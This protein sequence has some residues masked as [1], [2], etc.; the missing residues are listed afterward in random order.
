MIIGYLR[1][2]TK[3]QNVAAQ[4]QVI[5]DKYQIER[6]YEDQAASGAVKA[7]NRPEFRKMAEFVRQ[8][9][10]VVVVAIDRLGRNT[11]DVLETVQFLQKKGVAVTSLRE[12]FDLASPLGTAMLAIVSAFAELERS[13][14]K[15]R[16][17]A[18]IRNARE[19]GKK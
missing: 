17:M 14:I 9:D 6:W 15:E 1:V 7:L 2:S 11:I 16:Q 5:Q 10:T 12:N 18:G 19:E 8:G 13:Y 4:R 3:E